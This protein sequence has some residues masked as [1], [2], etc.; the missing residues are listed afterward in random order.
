MNKKT[1]N[2]NKVSWI[3]FAWTIGVVLVIMGFMFT[4]IG[5]LSAKTDVYQKDQVD[6]KVMLASIQSDLVWIKANITT[7]QVEI[8]KQK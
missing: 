7:M 3:I 6:M 1:N 5:N 4:Q 8:I 2:N